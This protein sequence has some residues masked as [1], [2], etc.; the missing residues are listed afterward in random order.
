[1]TVWR[2]VPILS[3]LA[4]LG[5]ILNHA[6]W[7]VLE[8]YVPGDP[9]GIG[10]I[11]FDQLGKFAIH[12]F[13]FIAGY[14][15]AYATS[16]G[17][18]PLNWAV[19]RARVIHLIWPWLIW[20]AIFLGGKW[21][22]GEPVS[23][24][25]ILHTLFIQYYYVPLLI[26]YYLMAVLIYR[27]AKIDCRR[28]LV[29]SFLTGLAAIALFYLRVYLPAFPDSLNALVDF[30][31]GYYLRFAFFF[32]FGVAAGLYPQRTYDLLRKFYRWLPW[33]TIF[34]FGLSLAETLL[35]YETGGRY[36]PVG[37]DHTKLSSVLFAIAML[38]CCLSGRKIWIPFKHL[39]LKAG[40]HSYGLYLS[41]YIILGLIARLC[42][43][44]TP[45]LVGVGWVYLPALFI[46]TLAV[47]MSLMEGIGHSSLKGSY[48]YL[49]G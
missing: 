49:F 4:I 22:T 34:C 7:H 10:Y 13:L 14:F 36:W 24:T 38:F 3:G 27:W 31:L 40:T 44:F 32:P 39:V 1:M 9:A 35:V 19:I 15:I 18:H 47:S 20:T 16:S 26:F 43:R 2:S 42:E 37:G 25:V 12:V 41:H 46:L 21:L 23:I 6:N 28:L 48:K 5:V 11:V 33:L 8:Q 30:G 45:G 29:F 17:K